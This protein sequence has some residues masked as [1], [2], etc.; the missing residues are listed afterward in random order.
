MQRFFFFCLHKV[1][2]I[3]LIRVQNITFFHSSSEEVVKCV[4]DMH[5]MSSHTNSCTLVD[6]HPE[7]HGYN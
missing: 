3:S 4:V 7:S 5:K 6:I 1:C 2:V